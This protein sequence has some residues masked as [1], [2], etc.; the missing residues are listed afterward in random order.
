MNPEPDRSTG[1]AQ[2]ATALVMARLLDYFG[3]PPHHRTS[4][5]T[6]RAPSSMSESGLGVRIVGAAD[7]PHELARSG[8]EVRIGSPDAF[9]PA[10]CDQ[11]SFLEIRLAF[12]GCPHLPRQHGSGVAEDRHLPKHRRVA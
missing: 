4:P 3:R 10:Q 9:N 6:N 2:N 8:I 7:Q 5:P 12:A 11:G 1:N